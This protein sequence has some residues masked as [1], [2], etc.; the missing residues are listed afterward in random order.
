MLFI[1]CRSNPP[2]MKKPLLFSFLL[3]VTSVLLYAQPT[4]NS[5][6]NATNIPLGSTCVPISG[7]LS[8]A[9]SQSTTGSCGS[10]RKDVWYKFTVSSHEVG[11][12]SPIVITVTR[13]NTGSTNLTNANTSTEIFSAITNTSNCSSTTNAS[14]GSC[15]PVGSS[16]TLSNLAAGTYYIRISTSVT[17][18]NSNATFDICVVA[19]AASR[20][21]EIFKRTVLSSAN[22]LSSPWEVTYGPDNKLW[23]TEAKGYKVQK[24]D[25]IDGGKTTVLDISNGATGYLTA[26]QHTAFNCGFTT[27]QS[28]WP[29]G[30]LAG[31]AL[32]PKFLDPDDPKNFVYISYVR[33]YT[34]G[35]STGP[36]H[37][38]TNRVVRFTYNT[39]TNK[40]ESPVSLC[41]TLPGSNDHNSQ[42]L[43]IAPV[44]DTSYLF[45]ASGDMGAGQGVNYTRT[46]NAQNPAS[47]EGKILRFHLEPEIGD[48]GV[49]DKW[50]PYDNPY[51]SIVS[52]QSAVWCIGMR[53]NQG[54]AYDSTTNLLYGTSHGPY[55]DDELNIIRR[56]KNYG[57]P[58]VIGYHSDGNYNGA[59]TPISSTSYSAGS[60]Y[61]TYG[62]I[63]RNGVSTC[64]PIGN[65]TTRKNEINAMGFGEYSD[66]LFSAYATNIAGQ[67]SVA[68]IWSQSPSTPGNNLWPSEG[69]S[70]LDL[71]TKS[72]I[73]GW[74][75][76]L[77]A[78]GL[79]WG[80]LLRLK[81]GQDGT[82]TLP[83]GLSMGNTSDT[84]T[85]LQ[86]GNRYRDLA[87]DPNGR[88]I[89]IIMDNSAASVATDGN[90]PA[91]P[92][93]QGC[94][95][96]YTFL[97]YSDYGGKS[98]IPT[99]I[100]VAQGKN[101]TCDSVNAV[102]I[103]AANENNDLWVPLTD[104]L[105]NI[106]AEINAM[107]QNLGRVTASVYHNANP[108]RSKSGK[109][110]LDRN[111]TITPQ[112]QPGGNVKIRLYITQS[113]YNNLVGSTGSAV[114]SPDDVKI[115]KNSDPC[116]SSINITPTV[117][118]MDF[119]TEAFGTSA[120]VLQGT[121]NSF[122]TFYFGS[123]ALSTLPLELITFKATLQNNNT[124]LQWE[125]SNEDNTSHF[126]VER[127]I[128]GR[129]FG[130]VG[131]VKAQGNSINPNHYA[132]TDYDVNNLSS[133]VIYYRLKMADNDGH[134]T[135]SSVV[136]VN[137]G[138]ITNRVILSPNPTTG[139]TRL[140][141]ASAK[142]GTAVWKLTDNNGRVVMRQHVNIH[143]GSNNILL[144]VSGL[145]NGLYYLHIT[146]AGIN[147]NLKL[148]KL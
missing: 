49:L 57:H 65:E 74:K 119:N 131:N 91:A 6:T 4:N 104:T 3:S 26:A 38:F 44:G 106:V 77:V 85:Y 41:D 59:T 48:P 99:S 121:T 130:L 73:P 136:S 145:K 144:N 22:V 69:W 105:S 115:F 108:V 56:F 60:P 147:Q 16:R 46:I 111:I 92:A 47:Y 117:V 82:T 107:G 116:S 125:T 110:Y 134:Y 68:T 103:N 100:P 98:T 78:A 139:D 29:Q 51:N 30:G 54:F 27:S 137:L 10:G 66:P 19:P 93:C 80:R 138:D 83:S 81:L 112:N 34:A 20:M 124:L 143:K 8:G 42:R 76:S 21:K 11:M 55:S 142:Q 114:D 9:T 5:C 31:L 118:T 40:L 102:T 79:K 17:T 1:F 71:Y 135:Y 15:Q 62:G 28:P 96:K 141:V 64:P 133:T 129:N 87:F 43:F 146:G 50:I 140:I 70:G 25:P 94:L 36:G 126:D 127:S 7:T 67:P 35:G 52:K 13:T 32:H 45:Y 86:S 18:P 89:Y 101:N 2:S 113:E 14:G 33:S 109:K 120:Y 12:G 128:D 37:H 63:S 75:R 58:L 84:I 39:V 95:V 97:G 23:V 72:N 122:S 132:H 24:I 148:Q 61:G 90:P 88:D 123:D 53:N